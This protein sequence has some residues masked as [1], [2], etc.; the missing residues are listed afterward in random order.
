MLKLVHHFWE[1]HE[2]PKDNVRSQHFST[3]CKDESIDHVRSLMLSDRRMTV[4]MIAEALHLGKSS[5][6]QILTEH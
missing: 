3:P 2:D 1:G 4:R 5:A 6:Q